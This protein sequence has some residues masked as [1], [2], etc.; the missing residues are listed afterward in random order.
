MDNAQNAPEITGIG[1]SMID[2]FINLVHSKN[3]DQ[4]LSKPVRSC[5]DYIESHLEEKLA[6][7]DLARRVGYTD[8]YLSRK[9]KSETGLSVNDYIKNARIRR[10]KT[11]MTTTDLSIQ[12]ISDIL[13]F[14]A[15]SFF[16]EVFK[17]VVGIP[18][19]QWRDENKV[20]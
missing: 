16:A 6:I 5:C 4:N 3:A 9:F 13:G 14:S 12:E 7:S 8:Y 17:Q 15:R 1:M 20:M 19:A 11:L 18:P 10:A 2:D